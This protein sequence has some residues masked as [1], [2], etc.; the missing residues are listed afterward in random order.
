ML[1]AI[2]LESVALLA[3]LPSQAIQVR[4][5]YCARC[6]VGLSGSDVAGGSGVS[7]VG[8]VEGGGD[9]FEV[10]NSEALGSPSHVTPCKWHLCSTSE[11]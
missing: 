11:P 4:R 7:G 9:G 10:D 5:T 1:F 6:V 3:P 2:F 8:A